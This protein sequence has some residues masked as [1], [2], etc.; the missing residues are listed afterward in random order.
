MCVEG[1]RILFARKTRWKTVKIKHSGDN[2]VILIEGV[3]NI[4]LYI[5]IF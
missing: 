5:R 1:G 4:L 2:D 3:D